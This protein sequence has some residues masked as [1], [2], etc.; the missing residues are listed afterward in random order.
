MIFSLKAYKQKKKDS[1][2]QKVAIQFIQIFS[3]VS[4][5]LKLYE[6]SQED[7]NRMINF[8]GNSETSTD[9]FIKIVLIV[10]SVGGLG[11]T[12]LKRLSYEDVESLNTFELGLVKDLL[13]NSFKPITEMLTEAGEKVSEEP[14][15]LYSSIRWYISRE[16]INKSGIRQ[17][18]HERLGKD[19]DLEQQIGISKINRV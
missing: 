1:I 13:S 14:F 9:M 16:Y 15:N 8:M 3:S 2:R 7:F 17:S 4:N 18:Y 12:I 10:H 11:L 6:R 19:Y 5:E